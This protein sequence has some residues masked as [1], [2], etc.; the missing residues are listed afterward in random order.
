MNSEILEKSDYVGNRLCL[1]RE[2]IEQYQGDDLDTLGNPSLSDETVSKLEAA[3]DVMVNQIDSIPAEHWKLFE[4]YWR[5]EWRSSYQDHL[6]SLTS[7]YK[8]ETDGF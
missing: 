2:V 8:A 3:L 7:R 1:I 6:N 4:N 5:S